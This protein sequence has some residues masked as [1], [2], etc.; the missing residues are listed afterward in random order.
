[1]QTQYSKTQ[2]SK[3]ANLSRC[4][5]CVNAASRFSD[6]DAPAPRQ[7]AA[8]AP[9]Q[10]TP[11]KPEVQLPLM[12][13]LQECWS[14][15]PATARFAIG[16]LPR[17]Y[18]H[19][20]ASRDPPYELRRPVFQH[21]LHQPGCEHRHALVI[22]DSNGT[23]H[24][25]LVVEPEHDMVPSLEVYPPGGGSLSHPFED[26]IPERSCYGLVHTMVA[27]VVS[28]PAG[29]LVLVGGYCGADRSLRLL[30]PWAGVRY[31]LEGHEAR[32]IGAALTASGRIASV[33]EGGELIIW[34]PSV[35]ASSMKSW[36]IVARAQLVPAV[37]RSSGN[38]TPTLCVS[39]GRLIATI[40]TVRATKEAFGLTKGEAADVKEVIAVQF[41]DVDGASPVVVRT[42]LLDL[43]AG[44]KPYASDAVFVRHS[45]PP[46]LVLSV[47]ST[48]I[49]LALNASEMSAPITVAAPDISDAA[50]PVP[51]PPPSSP[52]VASSTPTDAYASHGLSNDDFRRLLVSPAAPPTAPPAGP[53]SLQIELLALDTEA[54]LILVPFDNMDKPRLLVLSDH[55]LGNQA[56]VLDL[57][58]TPRRSGVVTLRNAHSYNR[59]GPECDE[60]F[61]SAAFLRD[62]RLLVAGTQMRD[63]GVRPQLGGLYMDDS[64]AEHGM[65][66]VLLCASVHGLG[67]DGESAFFERCATARA[68]TTQRATSERA[69]DRPKGRSKPAGG[70]EPR[71]EALLISKLPS[72]TTADLQECHQDMMAAVAMHGMPMEIAGAYEMELERAPPGRVRKLMEKQIRETLETVMDIQ[73]SGDPGRTNGP[74]PS[75][76]QR[77]S[78]P[79]RAS[80]VP[81]GPFTPDD[82]RAA[83]LREGDRVRLQGLA[84]RDDLNGKAAKIIGAFDRDKGRFPVRVGVESIKVKPANLDLLELKFDD[85]TCYFV[86]PGGDIEGKDV[87][88]CRTNGFHQIAHDVW[89]GDWWDGYEEG[90][91]KEILQECEQIGHAHGPAGWAGGLDSDESFDA[92]D[93]SFGE[94]SDESSDESFDASDDE[95]SNAVLRGVMGLPTSGS[96]YGF[97]QDEVEELAMQGIKPW[98]PE[99]RAALSVLFD[100]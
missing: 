29:D 40:D 14:G 65:S 70:K 98:D 56:E 39:C 27:L 61:Q 86:R 62:G 10:F 85:T 8:A 93:E 48:L 80:S 44:Y 64:L 43:L 66:R 17:R 19:P 73:D 41:W 12:R 25:A 23:E 78:K 31:R 53:P 59:H 69:G 79:P 84:S 26:L 77:T 32:P 1:M 7:F 88:W 89:A 20:E 63:D 83:G 15:R 13:T 100:Y 38:M 24:V 37:D 36:R 87:F 95:P 58:H 11:A 34:S 97:T 45:S 18:K 6:Y 3:P 92:S 35:S 49:S 21:T 54:R 4:K 33:D 47:D 28:R 72:M 71:G 82:P 16:K 74:L 50:P 60:R 75:K 30:D 55:M 52:P 68:S 2:W 22:R 46:R 91:R 90:Q 76:P 99:A 5:S 9:R 94:S 51:P 96:H 67:F 57:T 42:A 81:K